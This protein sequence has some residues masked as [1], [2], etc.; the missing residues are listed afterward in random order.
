MRSAPIRRTPSLSGFLGA[1]ARQHEGGSR[2]RSLMLAF[3]HRCVDCRRSWR[4]VACLLA[5][6]A[7]ERSGHRST[8]RGSA[9]PETR[10]R[11]SEE[12]LST[13]V[14][15]LAGFG[16]RNTLSD[17]DLDYAR[18][19]RRAAVD[20]RRAQRARARSCRSRSTPTSSRAR[21]ASR[22]TSISQRHGG[23]ARQRRRDASTSPPTTTR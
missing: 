12:R 14:Q 2:T 20:L 7:V 9:H 11:I 18:H 8:R 1:E 13:L 3:G 16:T 17:A 23:A 22:A 19:R 4:V 15:K 6:R 5:V 10:R 21:A